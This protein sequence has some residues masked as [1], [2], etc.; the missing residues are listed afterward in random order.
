MAAAGS[1][2]CEEEAAA[3]QG[4][5]GDVTSPGSS[6][7]SLPGSTVLSLA[8]HSVLQALRTSGSPQPASL[9]SGWW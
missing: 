4:S 6:S 7:L 3:S 2:R 8:E 1:P 5:S 9:L